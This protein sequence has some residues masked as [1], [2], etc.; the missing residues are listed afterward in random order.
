[1]AIDGCRAAARAL[2]DQ[3]VAVGGP[4]DR[5]DV[6]FLTMSELLAST[7]PYDVI[8]PRRAS[9]EQYRT[10]EIATTFLGTPS[11]RQAE[12]SDRADEWKV[13]G[14][15]GCPGRHEG[16]ARVVLDADDAHL[17]EPGDILVCRF[18]DPS[19]APAFLLADGLVIDV[20]SPASHGAVIAREL[21]LP[22]VIGTGDG[23]R[24]I[25]TATGFVSTATPAS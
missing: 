15:P 5:E 8:A 14:V 16:T 24:R 6:F 22:F 4:Q 3:L 1:M 21:A 11:P 10:L 18:T 25:R 23:T 20:G 9:W 17:L 7:P 2:G 12:R 19:W 13:T